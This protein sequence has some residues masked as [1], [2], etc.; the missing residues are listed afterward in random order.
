MQRARCA[1]S[2]LSCCRTDGVSESERLGVAAA[3]KKDP[4]SRRTGS[5][6]TVLIAHIRPALRLRIRFEDRDCV[7]DSEHACAPPSSASSR[8]RGSARGGG[9]GRDAPPLFF[10]GAHRTPKHTLGAE[11]GCTTRSFMTPSGRSLSRLAVLGSTEGTASARGARRA[12]RSARRSRYEAHAAVEVRA[13]EERATHACTSRTG[14][15]PRPAR[16]RSRADA[17][18]PPPTARSSPRRRCWRGSG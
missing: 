1:F 6:R 11:R 2:S 15:Q 10:F 17:S 4:P 16:R 12:T 9:E 7:A 3:R 13:G 5:A 14:T 18:H 8:G